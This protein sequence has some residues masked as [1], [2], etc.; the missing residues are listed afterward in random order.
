MATTPVFKI[1]VAGGADTG[2]TCFIHRHLTGEFIKS[3]EPTLGVEVHPLTLNTTQGKINLNLWDLAGTP[4]FKGAID[5]YQGAHGMLVFYDASAPTGA[6]FNEAMA[7]LQKHS[8]LPTVLCGS[9]ADIGEGSKSWAPFG[10]ILEHY[11]VS[12]RSNYNYE[13][14]FLALARTLTGNSALEITG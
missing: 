5:Y 14:P 13:K 6:S 10:I 3:Y 2:K 1:I 4:S 9:K 12:A 11:K 7:V 8:G